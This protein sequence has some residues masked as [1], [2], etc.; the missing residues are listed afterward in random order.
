VAK[1]KKQT[2]KFG[3]PFLAAA[4]FCE[5][6]L[7][8]A[9]GKI[10][11]IG[12]LDGCQLFLSNDAP[13]DVPSESQPAALVQNAL[14]IF[15]SGDSPGKHKLRLVVEQPN[16]KRI[17]TAEKD[18][19][20]SGPSH[21]GINLK[22]NLLLQVSASGVYWVDV[23]LDDKRVTRMPLNVTV[24]RLPAPPAAT[25]TKSSRKK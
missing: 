2:K 16:G 4:V 21:G 8:D 24:Q 1:D 23:I 11:A 3:G 15:R 17:K 7:E 25:P 9:S 12:I 13:P 22:T 20:L 19:D 5:S 14:F 10:S 6:T 18:I